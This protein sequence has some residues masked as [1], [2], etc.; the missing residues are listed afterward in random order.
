MVCDVKTDT[1]MMIV[2]HHEMPITNIKEHHEMKAPELFKKICAFEGLNLYPVAT[3]EDVEKVVMM[4]LEYFFQ[5]HSGQGI[6]IGYDFGC[7][8]NSGCTGK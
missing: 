2:N 8:K 5:I 3:V 1:G 6:M 4:S 7:N